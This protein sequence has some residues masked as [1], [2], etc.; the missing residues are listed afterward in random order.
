MTLAMAITLTM[1]L[2][3]TMATTA[4]CRKLFWLLVRGVSSWV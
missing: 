4:M 3:A 1:V 2:T